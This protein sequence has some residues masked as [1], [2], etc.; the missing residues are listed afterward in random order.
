MG[1]WE[2]IRAITRNNR[3]ELAPT[4]HVF[5]FL[6]KLNLQ[7]GAR[8]QEKGSRQE[9]C[10]TLIL[11]VQPE[12]E[13]EP[14]TTRRGQGSVGTI[15]FLTYYLSPSWQTLRHSSFIGQ[16]PSSAYQTRTTVINAGRI[17]MVALSQPCG[18]TA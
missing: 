12:S 16:Q 3:I 2:R 15:C 17:C 14:D 8:Q 13:A 7:S 10:N 9:T 4:H 11:N 1:H 5:P 18:E 6:P